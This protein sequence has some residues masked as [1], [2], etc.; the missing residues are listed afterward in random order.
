[1]GAL[2]TQPETA[3]ESFIRHES[4]RP[5]SDFL[6][7]PGRDGQLVRYSWAEV[8]DQARRI[9]RYLQS[10]DLPAAKVGDRVESLD[11]SRDLHRGQQAGQLRRPAPR[12]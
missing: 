5:R 2:T 12:A 7:E 11:L 10:L 1:M 6:L 8:G 3:L 9:A 4:L